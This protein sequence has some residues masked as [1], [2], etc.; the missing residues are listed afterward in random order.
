MFSWFSHDC[1]FSEDAFQSGDA[2]RGAFF[3]SQA[4]VSS[5][6]VFK[7]V[8]KL[9]SKLTG[10]AVKNYAKSVMEE[11]GAAKLMEDF[12]KDV[13]HALG[14]T[15]GKAL[16]VAG[17]GFDLAS[18]GMDIKDFTHLDLSKEVLSYEYIV[19]CHAHPT[20]LKIGLVLA[21]LFILMVWYS[22]DT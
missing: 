13:G 5:Y 15:V 2:A 1:N 6:T 7:D 4:I 14:G 19:A 20:L 16:P 3:T 8:S 10:E 9:T 12:G 22:V 18:I 21:R 11:M 17:I